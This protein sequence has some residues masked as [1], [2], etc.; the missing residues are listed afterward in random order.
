MEA[1]SKIISVPV[2]N[3]IKSKNW[4]EFKHLILDKDYKG[5]YMIEKRIIDIITITYSVNE[6][7]DIIFS[8]ISKRD[9]FDIN[10]T[11]TIYYMTGMMFLLNNCAYVVFDNGTNLITKN[12]LIFF[13]NG[14]DINKKNRFGET[15]LH[16][17]ARSNYYQVVK[18]LL[19]SNRM[20]T[21]LTNNANKT[22]YSVA[23]DKYCKESVNEF[24]L[25]SEKRK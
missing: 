19:N 8:I 2:F 1:N 15:A 23:L 18:I 22:A 16:I 13:N 11:E 25:Y 12:F 21:L 5:R 4:D 3:A 24:H 6:N 7:F 17:A 10:A 9:D 20:N 14:A